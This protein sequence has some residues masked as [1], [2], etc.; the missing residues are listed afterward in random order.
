MKKEYWLITFYQ[1]QY[2]SEGNRFVQPIDQSIPDWL[3]W[4]AKYIEENPK[5]EYHMPEIIFALPLTEE[6]FTALNEHY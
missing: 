3:L 5:Q 4:N 6:Q 1:Q 2:M